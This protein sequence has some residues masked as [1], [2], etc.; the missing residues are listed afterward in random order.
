LELFY[1]DAIYLYIFLF[2]LEY[3][4]NFFTL[5][6]GKKDVIERTLLISDTVIYY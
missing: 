2:N 6:N 5:N 3:I 4:P 1:I